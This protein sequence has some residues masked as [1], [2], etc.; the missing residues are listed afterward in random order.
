MERNLEKIQITVFI[1][2]G[3]NGVVLNINGFGFFIIDLRVKEG[4]KGRERQREN[5]DLFS[6][7]S[8]LWLILVCAL[9]GD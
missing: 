9:S 5:I 2:T 7:L 3:N 1:V 6:Y 4:G 8:I